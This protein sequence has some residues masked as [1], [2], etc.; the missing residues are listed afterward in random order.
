MSMI[1]IMRGENKVNTQ[2]AELLKPLY[3]D[4]THYFSLLLGGK[5]LSLA[6]GEKLALL[7]LTDDLPFYEAFSAKRLAELLYKAELPDGSYVDL[8]I[9]D[10]PSKTSGDFSDGLEADIKPSNVAAIA[11]DVVTCLKREYGREINFRIITDPRATATRLVV[12]D[13]KNP[14]TLAIDATYP[15]GSSAALFSS[16]TPSRN[17]PSSSQS[18]QNWLEQWLNDPSRRISEDPMATRTMRAN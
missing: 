4:V 17:E 12:V 18:L 7:D 13:T 8:L 3:G 9:N 14:S 1:I 6:A 2:A 15:S 11:L 5:K 10:C 16:E